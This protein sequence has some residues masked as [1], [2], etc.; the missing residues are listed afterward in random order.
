MRIELDPGETITVAFANSDGE[1][2]ITFGP[3]EILVTADLPDT[4]GRVGEIYREDFV[5]SLETDDHD[6]FSLQG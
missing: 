6:D 1:I 5:G 2:A 4:S 3:Q